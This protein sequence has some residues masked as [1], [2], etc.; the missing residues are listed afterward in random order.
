MSISKIISGGQTGASRAALDFALRYNISYDGWVPRGRVAE[1]GKIPDL[2]ELHEMPTNS[3]RARTEQNIADS[4]GTLII[5][6]GKLVKRSGAAY[7]AVIARRRRRPWLLLDMDVLTLSQAVHAL[8][9]WIAKHGIKVL[10]VT[11]PR[12]S[13]DPTIYVA[14]L[15]LLQGVFECSHEVNG[16]APAV[17]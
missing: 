9:V 3:H 13:E 2:Y 12:Q 14:T 16:S 7:A 11:G 4:D 1:D 5:S 8:E 17:D 6:H 10:N 15:E